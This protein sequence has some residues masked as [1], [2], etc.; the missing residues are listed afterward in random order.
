M[1]KGGDG[2]RGGAGGGMTKERQVF[3]LHKQGGFEEGR[4][5]KE[6]RTGEGKRRQGRGGK[7][8][9]P[10]AILFTWRP[11]VNTQHLLRGR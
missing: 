7:H 3:H 1:G 9:S 2:G 6:K 5:R 11:K 10:G 4:R 8:S